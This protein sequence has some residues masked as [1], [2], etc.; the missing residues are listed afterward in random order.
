MSKPAD[1]E[2]PEGRSLYDTD[3]QRA[4]E[5]RLRQRRNMEEQNRYMNDLFQRGVKEDHQEM[6]DR[7]IAIAYARY[8]PAP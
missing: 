2:Q 6:L 3:V 1:L 4:I 5:A 8:M 7:L